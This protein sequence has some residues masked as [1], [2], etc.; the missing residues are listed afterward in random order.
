M[1]YRYA[2]NKG[3]ASHPKDRG[4]WDEYIDEQTGESSYIEHEPKIVLQ[5]CHIS[6][7]DLE[8]LDMK[9]RLSL[10]KKCKAEIPFIVGRDEIVENSV[11]LKSKK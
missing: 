4:L 1:S 7:H 2:G 10:C 5:Q 6:N 11:F 8:V 9:K 3:E